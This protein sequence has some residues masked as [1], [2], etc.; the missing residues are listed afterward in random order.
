MVELASP[1][2]R[3][4][5]DAYCTPLPQFMFLRMDYHCIFYEK[6]KL[7]KCDAVKLGMGR[8]NMVFINVVLGAATIFG[9]NETDREA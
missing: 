8:G 6:S 9:R 3:M 2:L 1:A 7:L 4:S 5:G